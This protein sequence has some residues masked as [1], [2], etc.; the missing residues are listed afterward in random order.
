MNVLI[1]YIKSDRGKLLHLSDFLL[2]VL[3][4]KVIRRELASYNQGLMIYGNSIQYFQLV[5]Q[6]GD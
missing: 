1:N 4:L 5:R 2:L 6:Y 3:L